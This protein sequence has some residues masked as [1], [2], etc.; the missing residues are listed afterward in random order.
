MQQIDQAN[1]KVGN[2]EGYQGIVLV[3]VP[4][5]PDEHEKGPSHNYGKQFGQSMKEKKI[6]LTD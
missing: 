1:E 4:S 5:I 2:A 6:I 3:Y